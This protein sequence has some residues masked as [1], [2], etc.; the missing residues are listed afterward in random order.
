MTT[1]ESPTGSEAADRPDLLTVRLLELTVDLHQRAAAHNAALQREFDL[2]RIRTPEG[3][4]MR[5]MVL[6]EELDRRFGALNAGPRAELT[7]AA[8]QGVD[9]LD[10]ELGVPESA[11]EAAGRLNALL[12]EADE[13]CRAGGALVTLATP[14]ELRRYRRWVLGQ[15]IDQL[16]GGTPVS[17]GSFLDDVDDL[18]DPGVGPAPIDATGPVGDGPVTVRPVGDLDLARAGELR[19]MLLAVDP[20][21]TAVVIDLAG[22][23]F[24]D[25]V[26]LSVLVNH[27]QRFDADGV[28]LEIRVPPGLATLFRLTGLDSVL[29]LTYT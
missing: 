26:G 8:D 24:L 21:V 20:G 18:G 9:R 14:P 7:E 5:L 17:W 3:T 22:V 4:P 11:A 25:S 12:D 23:D 1:D 19:E 15:V 28:V 27:A 16:A 2:L 13:Y 6:V 10:L 29:S